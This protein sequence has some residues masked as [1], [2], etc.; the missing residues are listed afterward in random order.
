MEERNSNYE[1]LPKWKPLHF[2]E[3]HYRLT[4]TLLMAFTTCN[5][6]CNYGYIDS[7]Y[8]CQFGSFAGANLEE[9][10]CTYTR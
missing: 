5:S 4:L 10:Y 2:V 3:I 1:G 9:I 8:V 7:V 6:Q